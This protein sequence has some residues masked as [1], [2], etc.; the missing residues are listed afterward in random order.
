MGEFFGYGSLVNL[1]THDYPGARPVKVRG[2]ARAW[3]HTALREVAF[4]TAVPQ[5][6]AELDGVVAQVP[7]GDWDALDLREAAYLRLV[8][9]EGPSIYH[10]PEGHHA[11]ASRAHP[12][13]LSYLDTVVQGYLQLFGQDGVDR[14]FAT[15]QGWDAPIRDDRAAPVYPRAQGLTAEETALVDRKLREIGATRL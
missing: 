7:G 3:R 12:V 14:F 6:G 4:L 15:T 11:P 5:D 1:A 9:P 8:L 2:W 13:L 10:I